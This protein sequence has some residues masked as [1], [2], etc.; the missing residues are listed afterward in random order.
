VF[1][2]LVRPDVTG[3]PVRRSVRREDLHRLA[4]SAK[5][6]EVINRLVA[7][8]LVAP[9][10]DET[11]SLAYE[12]LIEVWP[13]L[14]DW[15][16]EE[17]DQRRRWAVLRAAA[18]KWR[19]NR[20]DRGLLWTG[21]AL[22]EAEKYPD[23]DWLQN[24]FLRWSRRKERREVRWRRILTALGILAIAAV[25]TLLLLFQEARR[26]K[27]KVRRQK[28]EIEAEQQSLL[29]EQAEKSRQRDKIRMSFLFTE[30]GSDRA[31]AED[32]SGS[33]LWYAEALKLF[34]KNKD[35]LDEDHRK[36]IDENFRLRLGMSWRGL[37]AVRRLLAPTGMSDAVLS[38][39]PDGRPDLRWA[40]TLVDPSLPDANKVAVWDLGTESPGPAFILDDHPGPVD[41]TSFR[42][43]DKLDL[44]LIAGRGA[45]ASPGGKGHLTLWVRERKGNGKWQKVH[46]D[47]P[48]LER[49]TQLELSPDGRRAIIA[50]E[51][52]KE[53]EP[54]RSSTILLWEGNGGKLDNQGKFKELP[55]PSRAIVNRVAVRPPS[56]D[57][58]AAAIQLHDRDADR[59][60]VRLWDGATG[61]PLVWK[62]GLRAA[63]TT[64]MD[65]L[66]H[67]D[68]A[69]MQHLGFSPDGRWLIT[70]A[71]A[72]GALSG[73][74][75]L[76]DTLRLR[77]GPAQLPVSSA[78]F[79]H[80]APVAYATFNGG[81]ASGS[82][83][84]VITCGDDGKAIVWTIDRGGRLV[85]KGK[86]LLHGMN[87]RWADF[88][89]DGRH[90]VTAGRDRRARVWDVQTESLA[91]SPLDH[92]GTV[93]WVGFGPDGRKVLSVS[94]G[95]NNDRDRKEVSVA[96]VWELLGTGTTW[97]LT[98][99]GTLR[100]AGGNLFG[101]HLVTVEALQGQTRTRKWKTDPD[102]L[103]NPPQPLSSALP[104]NRGVTFAEA[105]AQGDRVVTLSGRKAFLWDTTGNE[106]TRPLVHKKEGTVN[107][108]CFSPD[109]RLLITAAG[110]KGVKNGEVA[111]W[112]GGTGVARPALRGAT[113]DWA[114]LFTAVSPDGKWAIATG[115]PDAEPEPDSN[116]QLWAVLWPL[117]SP[118]ELIEL[119]GHHKEP[120]TFA[121]FSPDNR[122]VVTTSI[123]NSACVWH[124]KRGDTVPADRLVQHLKKHT[125]DVVRAAF[126][127]KDG[128]YLVTVGEEGTAIVW[129]TE[130]GR[131]VMTL[132]HGARITVALFSPADGRYL[133]T[134]G[135]DGKA[136]VWHFQSDPD[137]PEYPKPP[138]LIATLDHPGG[139][140]AA[141]FSPNGQ[142]LRTI[143]RP[144]PGL[145]EE[146]PPGPDRRPPASRFLRAP[147]IPQPGNT[148]SA[149]KPGWWMMEWDVQPDLREVDEI[150][151]V[152]A[153]V[154]ERTLNERTRELTTMTVDQLQGASTR[155]KAAYRTQFPPHEGS[156]M[157]LQYSTKEARRAE[158]MGL[159]RTARWHLDRAIEVA[160]KGGQLRPILYAHRAKVVAQSPTPFGR[161]NWNAVLSDYSRAIET[162][163]QLEPSIR[164]ALYANSA[165]ARLSASLFPGLLNPKEWETLIPTAEDHY[166]QAQRLGSKDLQVEV[167]MGD[168][169][170]ALA[171]ARLMYSKRYWERAAY[172]Y[173]QAI[174]LARLTGEPDPEVLSRRSEAYAELATTEP[175]KWLD[176]IEDCTSVI[177]KHPGHELNA[178][179]YERRAKA[180]EGLKPPDRASAVSDYLQSA[181]MYGT[182]NDTLPRAIQNLGIALKLGQEDADPRVPEILKAYGLHFAARA[183]SV[184]GQWENAVKHLKEAT[185][186]LSKDWGLWAELANAYERTGKWKESTEAYEKAVSTSPPEQHV[187]LLQRLA[188]A[189]RQAKD[190]DGADR[191]Y[192]RAI[193]RASGDEVVRLWQ[194]RAQT[195]VQAGSLPAADKVHWKKAI[196]AYSR[197]LALKQDDSFLLAARAAAYAKVGQLKEM[198]ADYDAA[199][200][201]QPNWAWLRLNRAVAWA[202]HEKW[203]G[204][205]DDLK[206]YNKSF[207]R[208][209]LGWYY[210]AL[211]QLRLDDGA[212]YEG[213]CKAM[214]AQ[215]EG[216]SNLFELNQTAWVIVL[217][218]KPGLDPARAVALADL[219][220]KQNKGQDHA[221]LNTKGVALYRA[222]KYEEAL[223]QLTAARQAYM[224]FAG[225]PSGVAKEGGS[226][227]DQLFLAMTHQRLEQTEEARKW[228][229]R[230]KKWLE[231]VEQAKDGARPSIW[232]RTEWNL[233]LKE[234][235]ELI[236]PIK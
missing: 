175:Q 232:Q 233:H 110:D 101:E 203:Q 117:D 69:P 159:W 85:R 71:G 63:T 28:A 79:L 57:I 6:D 174:E 14:I 211:T 97:Y 209:A 4:E 220:V 210:L 134:A 15:L 139:V 132:D 103:D 46:R 99:P 51:S 118:G 224:R 70:C 53:Q 183:Q 223:K 172:H 166:Q 171:K 141:S 125:A 77:P 64:T 96:Q 189:Y 92:I 60:E 129:E 205:L 35:V 136:R 90:V 226:A 227:S 176:V 78:R 179:L 44:L 217:G 83:N 198:A 235:E 87:V 75:E 202:E 11:F 119:R 168:A 212:G 107:H 111:V 95:V 34:D 33:V 109:G 86:P 124:V 142:R 169:Y 50:F 56:G 150:R 156:E 170:R 216:T 188:Y 192:D 94:G 76:W 133:V 59:G 30:A 45:A 114:F 89:P 186:Q 105:N 80:N 215:F 24:K 213:T 138:P 67:P 191:A 100:Y 225:A 32:R 122:Y 143:C 26:Q 157:E 120:V 29:K 27:E 152:A 54:S 151:S 121:V 88:S 61:Q 234:A 106:P 72:T 128:R 196:E 204:A 41:A 8:R 153:V 154:A 230:A 214:V 182:R 177:T 108:A 229:A 58:V 22:D 38:T 23:L 2:A 13:R 135:Q 48:R 163:G 164:A 160:E 68:K 236:G 167:R 116:K 20:F 140:M 130:S 55:L 181:R 180:Y 221:Y 74:A 104:S 158:A 112:D 10:R 195:H 17:R 201:R 62:T 39:A 102:R 145:D 173:S 165:I 1:T 84:Q 47:L 155:A 219:A 91:F 37:P 146:A 12:A 207:P 231:A 218:N 178:E 228:L 162:S 187:R 137:A 115:G 3:R 66:Q 131:E 208:D 40:A 206:E 21:R 197:A 193:A 184:P 148:V 144:A 194:A 82:S 222:N 113:T 25:I 149:E 81:T 98:T 42:A 18:E 49:V 65:S 185:K 199:L 147:A 161:I 200:A 7:A 16:A 190:W 73:S 31:D 52:R 127:P 93:A 123:D 9:E 126:S 19:D 43:T 5:V 36:R